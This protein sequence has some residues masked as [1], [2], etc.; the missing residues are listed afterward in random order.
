MLGSRRT[1]M[2]VAGRTGSWAAGRW[3]CCLTQLSA[4]ATCTVLP[5]RSHLASAMPPHSVRSIHGSR[6]TLQ[7]EEDQGPPIAGRPE[8]I[9]QRRAKNPMGKIGLAWLIGLPSGI[10]TFLVAKREV[11]RNRLKQLKVRRRMKDANEGEYQSERYRREQRDGQTITPRAVT[12]S[13]VM[14]RP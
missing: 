7:S 11:D 13:N 9:P 10:I 14:G 2:A 1:K 5:I 4:P 12:P 6:P 3:S 8:Y